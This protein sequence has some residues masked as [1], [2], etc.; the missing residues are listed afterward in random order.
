MGVGLVVLWWVTPGVSP[1]LYVIPSYCLPTARSLRPARP[2]CDHQCGKPGFLRQLAAP[3][4]GHW[5]STSWLL[6]QRRRATTPWRTLRRIMG[7]CRMCTS[8]SKPL[9]GKFAMP[10]PCSSSCAISCRGHS[11][12]DTE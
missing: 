1:V 3:H 7:T 4:S 10:K 5:A 2:A 11:D 6:G 12:E 8:A 9:E